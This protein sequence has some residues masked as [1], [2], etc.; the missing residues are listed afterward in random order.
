MNLSEILADWYLQNKRNLPWRISH[1]PYKIWLSEIILQQ[2]RVEQGL[3]YYLKI[4]KNYPDIK[5]LANTPIDEIL[6]NWQ[7][8]GYYSRARNLHDTAKVIDN[9]YN[10]RFPEHYDELLKLKGIGPYT[11][12]AVASIAFN[13]PVA[14]VDGNVFRFLARYFG[15][16]QP[17]NS[18]VGKKNFH[19][20]A[21]S[22]LDHDNP[23]RH[24]Q[25][26]MEFGALQCIPVNPDCMKCPLKSSCFACK[27]HSVKELPVKVSKIPVRE[28]YFNYL[29]IT[30]GK[31]IFLKQRMEDDIWKMLYEFP[32]I[33]TR[34]PVEEMFIVK[35]DEWQ[36]LFA[37]SHG[38]K[39]LNVSKVYRHHLTHQKIITRFFRLKIDIPSV[40]LHRKYIQTDIDRIPEY[41][42]SRLTERYMTDTNLIK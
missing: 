2:T 41:A 22:I 31:K 16:Y 37:E 1:S 3:A 11:A 4:I 40:N 34:E 30:W 32:L 25:A 15:I 18:S 10:G 38:I 39:I 24:N 33:E 17:I 8:L 29:V 21:L 20:V 14:V 12:A 23:G 42:V 35:S 19:K 13:E 5:H 27:N 26:I 7:G 28:R 36:E 9:E 6:K